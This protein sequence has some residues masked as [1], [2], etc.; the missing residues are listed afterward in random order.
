MMYI[1]C[2]VR[3]MGRE[4]DGRCRGLPDSLGRCSSKWKCVGEKTSMTRLCL[5]LTVKIARRG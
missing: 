4:S 3:S 2:V 5:W 1:R